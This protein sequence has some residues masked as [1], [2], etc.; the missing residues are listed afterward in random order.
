MGTM[1]EAADDFPHEHEFTADV[2]TWMDRII[3][4]D[5]SLPFAGIKFDRRTKGSAKRRDISI[6]GKDG[7]RR[8]SAIEW[9]ITLC[10]FAL[11]PLTNSTSGFLP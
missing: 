7:N 5:P 11:H 1:V 4:N 3:E 8:L 10:Q 2:V 6:L 9:R